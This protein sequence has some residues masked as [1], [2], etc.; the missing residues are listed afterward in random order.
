MIFLPKLQ[1]LFSSK[2]IPLLLVIGLF[3][4]LN[5]SAQSSK[6]DDLSDEQIMEFMR[7]AESSGMSEAQIEKAA[8]LQ[9][10]T[11]ADISKMRDRIKDVQNGSQKNKMDNNGLGNGRKQQNQDDLSEKKTE[12]KEAKKISR[13][14]TVYSDTTEAV[15]P[16]VFGASLFEDANNLS[17]EPNLRIATPKNYQLGPDDELLI[18]IFGT[19][20]DNYKVKVSPEGTVK[21]LNISPIY[22][23]GLT[24]DAASERIISR[25]RQLYQGLNVAGSGASAQ[26]TLGN[27]RSI[28][29]TITGEVQRPGSYTISSLATVFNALYLSGG[30]S[31]NGSFRNIRVIRDNKVVRVLDLYD[32]LLRADQKDNIRLQDQDVIRVADYES[33]VELSGEVKRPMIFEVQKGENL[34]DVLRFGGGF[35]DKAYTYSIGLRRNTPKELKL[36]DITSDEA[37][38]F[39]PQNGDKYKIGSIL[40][41]F[42]NRVFITGSVFRAG[43]Y[44]LE[45]DTRTVKNL[46]KKAEGLKESAFLSRALI[47]RKQALGGEK[48]IISF[49][50]AKVVKGEANDIN[51][52]RE[53]SVVIS[54]VSALRQKRFITINGQ[55]NKGGAYDY[56]E[57]MS[58]EDLVILAGGL[59]YGATGSKIEVSRRVKSDTTDIPSTQNVRIFSFEIDENLKVVTKDNKFTLQP[60]D[61]VQVRKLPRYE[62][63]KTVYINGEIKYPGYYTIKERSQKI[64][65]LINLAGGLEVGAFMKGARFYRDSL[66]LGVDLNRVVEDNN[67]ADNLLLVDGDSLYIPREQQTVKLTGELL[68]PLSVTYRPFMK[69]KDYISQAGGETQLAA[70]SKIFVKYANGSSDRVKNY[71]LFRRYPK[72]E[73]GSEIIVPTA[74]KDTQSKLSPAERV[75]VITGISSLGLVIVSVLN[76]LKTTK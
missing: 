18:D 16:V 62:N 45:N 65:D 70:T 38:A 20:L 21:I 12:K 36:M 55:V 10:F 13:K 2:K 52:Q 19:V 75:G 31:E 26:V 35:T 54:M 23:N 43:E 64:S 5:L 44:A 76:Y 37:L 74:V 33:R 72:V 60:F 1:S 34:K 11:A 7:K 24:I 32:F 53:D 4:S 17:F 66:L 15:M 30:P 40:N 58:I 61:M 46:I 51:L 14:I 59:T 28:K 67:T 41:R 27:V 8:K 73:Q 42:E 63:Q 71:W 68:N 57:N 50:L 47:I 3:F 49:D 29:V 39:V 22:V 56:I 25:L 9:G 48:E 6:V 69:V